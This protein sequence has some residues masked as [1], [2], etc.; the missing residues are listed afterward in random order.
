MIMSIDIV[1]SK[2]S[3]MWPLGIRSKE[4]VPKYPSALTVELESSCP[5]YA[6]E[7]LVRAFFETFVEPPAGRGY[8]TI[9]WERGK[10]SPETSDES[11]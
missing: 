8:V 1:Q 9:R 10:I 3:S 7:L 6:P 2:E 11:S 5:M 4:Y